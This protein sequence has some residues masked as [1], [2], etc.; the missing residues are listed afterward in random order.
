MPKSYSRRNLEC[1]LLTAYF[2]LAIGG[3]LYEELR[4]AGTRRTLAF[5]TTAMFERAST[6][7]FNRYCGLSW[8]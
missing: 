3:L 6:L 1:S 2:V 7:R 8:L 4:A 5:A